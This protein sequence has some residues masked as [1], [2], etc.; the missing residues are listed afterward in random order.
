MFFESVDFSALELPPA[1]QRL[2]EE[3]RAF[4]K[5]EVASGSFTPHL[6]HAEFDAEFTRKIA[7]RGW[8]GMTWPKRYGGGE[9]SYLERFVVTEELLAAAGLDAV[10]RHEVGNHAASHDAQGAG[11]SAKAAQHEARL[12]RVRPQFLDRE[13]RGKAEI[14]IAQKRQERV[15]QRNAHKGFRP[16]QRSEAVRFAVAQRCPPGEDRVTADAKGYPLRP[17]P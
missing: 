4:L 13:Q 5:A 9:R 17:I 14:G 1:A 16:E 11:D 2:R 10:A 8:I 3:V 6:G 15:A 7:A 12:A